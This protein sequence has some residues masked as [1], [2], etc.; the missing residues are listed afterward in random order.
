MRN[1]TFLDE[2]QCENLDVFKKRGENAA[3]T[4]FSILLGGRVENNYLDYDHTLDGRCG[5]W[6]LKSVTAGF[7]PV[8]KFSSKG[9]HT[10]IR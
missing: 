2:K 10:R 3:I 4:D 5:S 7:G 1:F 8:I 6:W 9:S